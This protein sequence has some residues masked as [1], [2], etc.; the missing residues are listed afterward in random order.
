VGGPDVSEC[1]RELG[2]D[3]EVVS[4]LQPFPPFL[5][6]Y[7]STSAF[8]SCNCRDAADVS[9][10]LHIVQVSVSLFDNSIKNRN[11]WI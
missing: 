2:Y 7:N 11:I 9:E 4:M 5:P 3:S 10:E 6:F 8:D 1:G